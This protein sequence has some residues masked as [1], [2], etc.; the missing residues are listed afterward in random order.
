[1]GPVKNEVENKNID[2]KKINNY[3]DNNSY[4]LKF[5]DNKELLKPD[6]HR[7]NKAFNYIKK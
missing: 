6:K 5:K 1:M 7:V 2:I 4:F 3:N